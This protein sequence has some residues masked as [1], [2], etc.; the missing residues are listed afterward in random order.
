MSALAVISSEGNRTPV[1]STTIDLGADDVPLTVRLFYDKFL[2]AEDADE[3]SHNTVRDKRTAFTHWE[4]YTRNPDVREAV[5]NDARDYRD[6]LLAGGV[7]PTKSNTYWSYIATVFRIA[8]AEGVVSRRPGTTR[9]HKGRLV[10]VSK[11]KDQRALVTADEINPLV[12]ACKVATYPDRPWCLTGWR[13]LLL[14]YWTYGAR[15]LDFVNMTR[16]Q[17]DFEANTLEFEAI[18]TSKLQRLPLTPSVAAATAKLLEL[19]TSERVF[20]GWSSPGSW[21][22][23]TEANGLKRLLPPQKRA[24]KGGYRATWNGQIC[25]AAGVMPHTGPRIDPLYDAAK[26]FLAPSD[27]T[28]NAEAKRLGRLP[29][30]KIKH[31]RELM[32]SEVNSMSGAV[33]SVRKLGN[34][35]A[36]HYMA[37]VSE[38]HYDDPGDEIAAVLNHRDQ[39]LPSAFRETL[40]I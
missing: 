30:V 20:D 16:S 6:G 32:V 11:T 5:D 26:P 13:T 2:A 40:G 27:A 28:I 10:K 9:K 31:F 22:R 4:R 23:A 37:G 18:K 1:A 14:L 3:L 15:T 19:H 12:E 8:E 39:T 34:W 35:I 24:W 25:E 7:S 29:V 17:I 36:A 33:G 38:Q 21:L